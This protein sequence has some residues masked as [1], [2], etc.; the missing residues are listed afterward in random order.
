[1]KNRLLRNS[2]LGV[3][4]SLA[5]A[6]ANAACVSVVDTIPYTTL[7]VNQAVVGW[8]PTTVGNAGCY[9]KINATVTPDGNVY[10]PS[11]YIQKMVGGSWQTVS[12]STWSNVSTSASETP[13]QFRLVMQN[14]RYPGPITVRGTVDRN[15]P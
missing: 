11:L 12:S 5:A 3:I 7:P 13:G 8:G 9:A 15:V 6:G 4:V 1:M 10:A 14:V 2:F